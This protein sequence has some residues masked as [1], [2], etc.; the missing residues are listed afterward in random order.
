MG[1]RWKGKSKEALLMESRE[2][3]G[4]GKVRGGGQES[5]VTIKAESSHVSRGWIMTTVIAGSKGNVTL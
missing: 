4:E 3:W 5:I 1:H 2:V